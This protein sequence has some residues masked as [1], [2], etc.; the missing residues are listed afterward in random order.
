MKTDEVLLIEQSE[1]V[2]VTADALI[3]VDLQVA[4]VTGIEAVPDHTRLLTAIEALIASARAAKV[5]VIFL[6]NDGEP[7]AVD[8]PHR[9]GWE[10]HFPPLPGERV[11]RK[12][13]D[14]GF[15]GTSLNDLLTTSGVQSLA[16]CGVLSEMCVAA[17]ARAAMQRGYGVILPHDGHATYD[18]PPGP[19]GS[20]MVP[21]AMA[22]RAAEWS[23]G[24]EI[25][26]LASVRDVRFS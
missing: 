26:I 10:L 20:E 3:V 18:V 17:T 15:E 6:Q 21:A 11:V 7:G 12:T 19:G 9:P 1:S 8:E 4:F 23:L 24:D 13:A 5:P 25:T 22:A 16:L 2:D 14:D